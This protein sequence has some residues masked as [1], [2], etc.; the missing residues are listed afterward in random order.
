MKRRG[1]KGFTLIEL[2]VV[3]TII[4]VLAAILIPMLSGY[5]KK[6]YKKSDVS[7]GST[8][9]KAA[10]TI[11]EEGGDV[12]DSFYAANPPRYSVSATSSGNT[13]TYDFNVVCKSNANCT[14]WMPENADSQDFC[15]AMN[16]SDYIGRL[17]KV[18][19]GGP[20][21]V[22]IWV[23][24]YRADDISEIE[25]WTAVGSGVDGSKPIYRIWP[26]PDGE[27]A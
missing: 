7:A 12:Y 22:Q 1:I 24:G 25:V 13:E 21:K 27:Y 18:K 10:F 16:S 4:G 14:Q 3:I 26:S 11:I 5:I 2:I 9:G 15:D 6:S 8:I 17:S 23:I 20:K 19:Y